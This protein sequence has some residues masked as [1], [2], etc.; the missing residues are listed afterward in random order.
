M[1]TQPLAI[2]RGPG[3]RSLPAL[4]LLTALAACGGGGADGPPQT[5]EATCSAATIAAQPQ[6]VTVA[7]GT[8]ATFTVEANGT[9]PLAYQWLRNG[10]AIAGAT[11]AS[12][13]LAAPGSGDSGAGYNVTVSNCGSDTAISR[14]AALTV[15]AG[16]PTPT[17]QTEQ[18][19]W[20]AANN[21]LAVRADGSVLV[22]GN[23]QAAQLADS[24]PLSGTVA[25]VL[26][27]PVGAAAV[28]GGDV[29][30]VAL[31]RDG[32]LYGWGTNTFGQLGGGDFHPFTY[33]TV[34]S[35]RQL[36]GVDQVA[37]AYTSYL[38]TF[39]LRHDGT[40]WHWPGTLT[41]TAD[42]LAYD[43]QPGQVSG[44]GDV[45]ALGGDG[46]NVALAV[47]R[48]GTVW[49]IALPNSGLGPFVATKTQVANVSNA[50]RATCGDISSCAAL[51]ADGTVLTWS[52]S[53]G[54]PEP[55][56]GLSGARSLAMEAST[57][58]VLA[59]KADGTVWR[60][61]PPNGSGRTQGELTQVSGLAGAVDI[62]SNG[63]SHMVRLADGTL[64]GW[65]WNFIH[66]ILADGTTTDRA[67]PVQAIGIQLN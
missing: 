12:Y 55:V 24:A 64:W 33:D 42:P 46:V 28:G 13:T 25:R 23:N 10:T 31:G 45:V 15:T 48:D 29:H 35:P 38:Y 58:A 30:L 34:A 54:L 44:L 40:V 49:D 62:V 65:G 47:K 21:G 9:P 27:L 53:G 57:G 16:P 66:G 51:L 22:W 59:V 8:S 5:P 32:K 41:R 37:A 20:L 19:L 3:P 17:A 1:K 26:P 4:A 11:A 60:W 61:L 43:V 7:A 56:T 36:T 14:A 67:Q 18:R 6:D 63:R 50:V 52:R 2:R 39:A